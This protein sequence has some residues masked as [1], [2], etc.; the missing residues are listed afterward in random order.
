[1]NFEE[2]YQRYE[3]F[4]IRT[5]GDGTLAVTHHQRGQPPHTRR[6]QRRPDGA[7]QPLPIR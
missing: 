5:T 6:F 7:L 4:E 3:Y 2:V 1:M